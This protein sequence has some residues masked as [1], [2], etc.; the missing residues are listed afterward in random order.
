MIE[1]DFSCKAPLPA[2]YLGIFVMILDDSIVLRVYVALQALIVCP[3][4][5]FIYRVFNNELN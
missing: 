2:I 5:G 4:Y 3:L 1:I